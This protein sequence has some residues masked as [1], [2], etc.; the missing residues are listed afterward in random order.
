VPA[1]TVDQDRGGETSVPS[2]VN[3]RGIAPPGA[4]AAL[5]SVS[6][7]VC[8]G[9]GDAAGGGGAVAAVAAVGGDDA[10]G[11]DDAVGGGGAVA[12]LEPGEELPQPAARS[13]TSAATAHATERLTSGKIRAMTALLPEALQDVFE[14][15]I[16]TEYVTVDAHG[17]PIAWPVTPYYR[18]GGLTIDVTTGLGYPKKATDARANPK[19]ALLFSDP[20]GSGLAAPP[21]LLVQGTATV[22]DRDLQANRARY[23]RESAAKLPAASKQLPPA[24]VRRFLGWYFT[25][26]YVEVRPERIYAWSGDAGSEP[27]VYDA[28]VEEV[29]SGHNEEPEAEQA[30]PEGG[31]ILWDERLSELGSSYPTAVLA[32]VA[33]DGFPFAV[34]VPVRAD[35]VARRIHIDAEPAGVP[36][37]PG[38]ACVTAHSHNPD[39][40]W[41]QNF[42]VRG[43]LVADEQGWSLVPH[44]LISGFELPPGSLLARLRLNAR[45]VR[46]FHRVAKREL[47]R[48]GAVR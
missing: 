18:R 46:R 5:R 9:G 2:Q 44:R 27:E 35:P 16:T 42:Q 30:G 22:D 37:Q 20:T 1:G 15:F 39:F 33:P 25:R 41:Q 24:A 31:A 45:K 11:G 38:L 21:T 28:H 40:T 32:L 14:R 10:A 17:Q 48:R 19:V 4:N 23:E 29:R 43:D 3:R 12:E 36:W 13:A 47:T 34:R 26:I 8:A 7:P 6:A